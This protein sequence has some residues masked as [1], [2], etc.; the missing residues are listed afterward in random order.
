MS[1]GLFGEGE[2]LL[3]HKENPTVRDR[4]KKEKTG[5]NAKVCRLRG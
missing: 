5:R 4:E 1:A 2:E 3:Q